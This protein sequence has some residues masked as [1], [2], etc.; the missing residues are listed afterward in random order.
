MLGVKI[1]LRGHMQVSCAS[2]WYHSIC[3]WV[4]VNQSPPPWK[5]N[6]QPSQCN[7]HRIADQTITILI[8]IIV[9]LHLA[10]V[11]GAV[12]LTTIIMRSYAKHFRS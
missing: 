4:L 1:V 3:A 5:D 2:F 12:S 9:Q 6:S 11:M 7:R 8:Q 10:C